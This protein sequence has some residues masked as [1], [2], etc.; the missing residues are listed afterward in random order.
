MSTQATT[1]IERRDIDGKGRT[2]WELFDNRRYAI[3]S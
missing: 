1:D 3:D 2:L